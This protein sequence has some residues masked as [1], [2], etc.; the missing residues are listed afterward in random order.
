MKR[1][2]LYIALIFASCSAGNDKQVTIDKIELNKHQIGKLNSHLFEIEL[3]E[4]RHGLE[5][6]MRI[7]EGKE[8]LPDSI[9]YLHEKFELNVQIS[10]L[11]RANDS[12]S[13]ALQK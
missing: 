12:L 8:R 1:F 10:K 13:L 4:R 7:G 3:A 11:Q 9:N 2:L 6:G 5:N